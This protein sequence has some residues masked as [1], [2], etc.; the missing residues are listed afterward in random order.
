[1]IRVEVVYSPEPGRV[2][3]VVL[4]LSTGST[5]AQALQACAGPQG[6]LSRLGVDVSQADT[7]VW[8]RRQPHTYPLRDGDRVEI[9]RPLRCDPKEA[10]RRRH[11]KGD[12]STTSRSKA[13]ARVA[14]S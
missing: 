4:D 14:G 2:D 1:M 13:S 11:R 6:W 10:R 3:G 5:V 7:G 9:Y 8:G 12:R